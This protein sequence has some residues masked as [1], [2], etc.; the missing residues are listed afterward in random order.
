MAEGPR[1]PR[2]LP[3]PCPPTPPHPTKPALL[4]LRSLRASAGRFW[5]PLELAWYSSH[6]FTP[7]VARGQ[8]VAMG[9]AVTHVFAPLSP[10]QAVRR[11][12]KSPSSATSWHSIQG[13]LPAFAMCCLQAC[14]CG[15]ALRAALL[16]VAAVE[17][18][19][20]DAADVAFIEE[21]AT[22][23][24]EA[25]GAAG[26]GGQG[27]GEGSMRRVGVLQVMGVESRLAAVPAP[28]DPTRA[29]AGGAML[30][31]RHV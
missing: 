20:S 22:A 30:R 6:G 5:H 10:Y 14:P 27:G 26:G 2:P 12:C 25:E 7:F 24:G 8:L 1:W 4:L 31:E 18:W 28:K 19:A 23:E 11:L 21:A 13:Y 15:H 17:L 16:Q 29:V 9:E 3:S